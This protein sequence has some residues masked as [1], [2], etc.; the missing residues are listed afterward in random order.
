MS[1]YWVYIIASRR[2]VL[3]TGVTND[4]ERRIWEHRNEKKR[5]FT[6][7]YR[8]YRLVWAQHFDDVGEA[9]AAEKLVKSWD[10]QK[11]R[12]L[13]EDQNPNWRDMMPAGRPLE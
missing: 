8:I 3:Y 5:S 9:I 10:R 12:R 11:K 13:I 2:R 4:L 1:G 6:R 7:R